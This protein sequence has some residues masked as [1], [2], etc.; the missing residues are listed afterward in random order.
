[1]VTATPLDSA[2]GYRGDILT[3]TASF[4]IVGRR[5]SLYG[6]QSFEG[7]LHGQRGIAAR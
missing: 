1:M 5:P 2:G 6:D 7:G 3:Q 4:A